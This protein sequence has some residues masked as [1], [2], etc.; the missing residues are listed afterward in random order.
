[1]IKVWTAYAYASNG[2][3]TRGFVPT[4]LRCGHPRSV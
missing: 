1:M 2:W 3:E 4:T